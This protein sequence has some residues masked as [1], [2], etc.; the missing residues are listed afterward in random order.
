[1]T[2]VRSD[3]ELCAQNN[4]FALFGIFGEP[5]TQQILSVGILVG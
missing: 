1:M 3:A 2:W 5:F 4:I